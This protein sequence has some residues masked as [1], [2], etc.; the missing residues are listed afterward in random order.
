VVYEKRL[1][2]LGEVLDGFLGDGEK[3]VEF[4]DLFSPQVAYR[5]RHASR[6][7]AKKTKKMK[8]N[9]QRRIRSSTP[10]I[11]STSIA[12]H[13]R[14]KK[15]IIAKTTKMKLFSINFFMAAC[16]IKRNEFGDYSTD[17]ENGDGGNL[18]TS[19]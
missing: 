11:P 13:N 15:L 10:N 19:S 12:H 4:L 18:Y 17:N 1:V 5:F 3:L 16:A 2:L 6:K 9:K 14:M 7:K 8:R